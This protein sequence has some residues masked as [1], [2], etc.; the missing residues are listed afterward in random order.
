MVS[1]AND[2]RSSSVK[3]TLLS[4]HWLSS[5]TTVIGIVVYTVHAHDP[6]QAGCNGKLPVLFFSAT[7]T[8]RL[9]RKPPIGFDEFYAFFAVLHFW[10]RT[11]Y[12][13]LGYILFALE[14]IL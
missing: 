5:A 8:A 11:N 7:A 12:V 10:Y 1:I 2:P 6:K 3:T 9:A 14:L 13:E 4:S